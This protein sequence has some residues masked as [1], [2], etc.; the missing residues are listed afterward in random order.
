MAGAKLI[1]IYP[2]PTD[3]ESFERV[4]QNQH[5]PM[6][7]EKLAGKTKIVASKIIGSPDGAPLF[8]RVAEIH[9]PSMDALQACA[10]SDG[11]KQT[12]ANAVAISSGGEPIFLVAE[13]ETFVFQG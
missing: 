13:E 11:G 12:I 10:A 5:V 2:R 4:Y 6:A 1:V 9:F 3:L 7:V 8:H